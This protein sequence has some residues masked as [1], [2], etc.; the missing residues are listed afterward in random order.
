M[1]IDQNYL[2]QVLKDIMEIH[3]PSGFTHEV[4]EYI[5]KQASE[6]GYQFE[7]NRKGGGLITVPGKDPSRTVCVSAHMD[8]LG[9]MVRSIDSNG[10][11]NFTVIGGPI[12][13]TLD[14]EYCTIITRS[15]KRYTGTFLSKSPAVHVFKDAATRPRDMENMYVRLDAQVKSKEDTEKLGISVGD[16]ICFDVKTQFVEGFVKSR[17][18]DDKASVACVMA[19]LE[20]MFTNKLQPNYNLIVLFSNYEEVGH[21]ASHIPAEIDEMLAVDMGCIGLD[22]SCTEYDVSICAKDSSGPYD[23]EMTSK[24]IE[25]AKKNNVPYAVDIYPFYGSD[26]SAALRGGN[27]IRAAL[28]GPGV[29][30]SH[31]M[32][33]TTEQALMGTSKIILS[34][35]TE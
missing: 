25:F 10:Q 3:S 18:L 22:L 5:E 13:P 8:T 26:A 34:Y 4:M 32:E 17:F 14:A 7:L 29:H 15:G 9:A 21:G 19:V 16:F 33:R 20:H 35:L 27:N 2:N 23:Y 6:L 31:G 30:A 24:L 1:S 28:I 11:L 12:V